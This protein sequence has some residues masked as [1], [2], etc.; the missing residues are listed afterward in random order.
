MKE[1]TKLLIREYH[2]KQLGYDFMGYALQKG[3][4]P[5]YHHLIVPAREGGKET[6][7][8]GAVLF[9]T[10]HNYLHVIENKDD[11]YFYYITSEIIDMKIKGWLDPEN[12]RNINKILNEFEQKYRFDE[13]SKGKRLIKEEYKKRVFKWYFLI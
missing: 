3:D 7:E 2:I 5:T 13:T 12:L 11:I 9:S 4:I 8:N 10:S 1:V 6:I